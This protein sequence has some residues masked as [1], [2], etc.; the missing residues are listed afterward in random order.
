MKFLDYVNDNEK[1]ITLIDKLR[2]TI[3]DINH[4]E[5]KKEFKNTTSEDRDKLSLMLE[6]NLISSF[7]DSEDITTI[8]LEEVKIMVGGCLGFYSLLNGVEKNKRE[9]YTELLWDILYHLFS[10]IDDE[11]DLC[12]SSNIVRR[13]YEAFLSVESGDKEEGYLEMFH[14]IQLEQ[15]ISDIYK[16][17]LKDKIEF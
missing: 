7:T 11:E 5:I 15:C 14:N 8:T 10:D 12:N 16:Y 4:E 9:S 13:V 3:K 1:E 17:M 2:R 6:Y